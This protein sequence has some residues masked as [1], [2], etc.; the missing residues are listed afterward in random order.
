[1]TQTEILDEFKKLPRKQRLATFKKIAHFMQGEQEEKNNIAQK[2]ENAA[3]KLL[4]DYLAGGDLTSFT[5]LDKEDF[6]V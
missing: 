1:M 2:L 3:K 4:P 6:H 5:T